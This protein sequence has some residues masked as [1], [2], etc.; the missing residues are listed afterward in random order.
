MS[1]STGSRANHLLRHHHS[2]CFLFEV[3]ILGGL[4]DCDAARFLATQRRMITDRLLPSVTA[5]VGVIQL[6]HGFLDRL[7]HTQSVNTLAGWEILGELLSGWSFEFLLHD[8]QAMGR[9][10]GQAPSD[11]CQGT[12]RLWLEAVE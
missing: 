4:L 8:G 3:A 9:E 12:A 2:L 7:L 10:E 5:S 6:F 11:A 1:S